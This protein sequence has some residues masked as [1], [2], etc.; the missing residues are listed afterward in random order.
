VGGQLGVG[1][2]QQRVVDVGLDHAGLQIV[3]HQPAGNGTEECEGFDVT[4][5]PGPLVHDEHRPHEHVAGTRQH[6][7]ER[8]HPAQAFGHGV[9]PRAEVA[10]VDLCFRARLHVGTRWC[11][12][13]SQ[14]VL[15]ELAPHVA[16]EAREAHLEPGFVAQALVHGRGRV[17]LEHALDVGPVGVDR[18][19]GEAAPAG[20]DQLGEPSPDEGRPLLGRQCFAA[21]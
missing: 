21:G 15:G 16:A 3:A 19:V 2:V 10:V 14:V 13:V 8:P 4:L 9:E 18:V 17:G 20:V 5:G 7:D 12:D 1:A 11:G 6:H